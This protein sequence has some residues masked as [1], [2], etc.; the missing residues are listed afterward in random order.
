MSLEESLKA[1]L[2][3]SGLYYRL[4]KKT[5]KRPALFCFTAE[6]LDNMLMACG[7]SVGEE[8]KPR[9]TG[10]LM[11]TED[12]DE[13]R[14]IARLIGYPEGSVQ[15]TAENRE[16]VV[17][18]LQDRVRNAPHKYVTYYRNGTELEN[19]YD[20]QAGDQVETPVARACAQTVKDLEAEQP[21]GG[22]C[23]EV[24]ARPE[25]DPAPPAPKKLTDGVTLEDFQASLQAVLKAEREVLPCCFHTYLD[26]TVNQ[27]SQCC[28]CGR[29]IR[30]KGREIPDPDHG[31]RAGKITECDVKLPGGPC[32]ERNPPK[33]SEEHD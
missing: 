17:A 12:P 13:A 11:T 24:A 6:D 25:G 10:L 27:K 23:V 1:H 31:P 30:H 22:D 16:I 15:V 2:D 33:T 28:Y 29:W 21:V 5:K 3:D 18:W 32:L 7:T 9:R 4:K 8:T 19:P 26:G 20:I 14:E